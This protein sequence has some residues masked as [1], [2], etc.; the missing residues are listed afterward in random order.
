M[1]YLD[2]LSLL[3][4]KAEPN[5]KAFFKS[6]KPGKASEIDKIFHRINNQVFSHVNC[7][8]CANCCKTLGPRLSERDIKKIGKSLNIKASEFEKQYLIIDEDGDYVFKTMPCP[9][10]DNENFCLIYDNRPKACSD[11]PHTHQPEILRKRKITI[12]NSF[13]CPAVYEI[14]EEVKKSWK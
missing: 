12:K 1:L 6:I 11:Y 5:N 2:K 10:L 4:K 8:E 7:L 3:S 9:F 14:L 13:T